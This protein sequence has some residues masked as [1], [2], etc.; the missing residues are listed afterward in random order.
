ME[1]GQVL[2][3]KTEAELKVDLTNEMPQKLHGKN[4][5]LHIEKKLAVLIIKRDK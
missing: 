5:I 4:V 1:E 3:N 2:P